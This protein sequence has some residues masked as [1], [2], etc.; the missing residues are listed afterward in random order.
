MD[1]NRL[2][3]IGAVLLIGA[4][5]VLGWVLAISPKLAQA[6]VTEESLAAAVS[7]NAAYE[8]QAET[9]KKQFENLDALQDDLAAVQEAVPNS[10]QIPAAIDEIGAIAGASQVSISS[11]IHNEAQAFDPV[12]VGAPAAVATTDAATQTDASATGAPAAATA[13]VIDPRITATTFA[14][15]PV[16][17]V[18]DGSGPA[19]LDF[20]SGLQNAARLFAVTSVSTEPA[21]PETGSVTTT[22]SALMYVYADSTILTAVQ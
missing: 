6:Q 5:A 1:K 12:A 11:I 22:I 14:A 18:V 8:A 16:V 13:P 7:E 17:I 21:A 10:A 20:V 4:I 19:G 2:W 15:I 3:V 9:F